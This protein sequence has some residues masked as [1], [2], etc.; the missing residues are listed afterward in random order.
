[1]DTTRP[2]TFDEVTEPDEVSD[3]QAADTA[4]ATEQ[5]ASV[6]SKSET[7]AQPETIKQSDTAVE[8][9]PEVPV[10]KVKVIVETT[11]Q[12]ALERADRKDVQAFD[13]ALTAA[14]LDVTKSF[15]MIAETL[16]TDGITLTMDDHFYGAFSGFSTI[17]YPEDIEKIKRLKNVQNVFCITRES[18]HSGTEWVFL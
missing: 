16:K 7:V 6:T 17:V 2:A 13:Q 4:I 15:E 9:K 18:S 10:E 5:P 1:M 11:D 8:A 3:K 14:E 12:P